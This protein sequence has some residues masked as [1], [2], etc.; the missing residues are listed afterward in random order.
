MEFKI[1]LYTPHIYMEKIKIQILVCL[2]TLNFFEVHSQIVFESGYFIN[3]HNQKIECFIKDVDWQ[4]NPYKFD[5][6]L[7]ETSEVQTLNHL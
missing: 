5:Y 7:S 6:K 3:D 4:F 2:L 1:K